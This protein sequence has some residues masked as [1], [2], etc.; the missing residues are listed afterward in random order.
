MENWP[1]FGN[2]CWILGDN[3]RISEYL[4]SIIIFAGL[5]AIPITLILY[6]MSKGD[7]SECRGWY[8]G[9]LGV[10]ERILFIVL[11][12]NEMHYVLLGWLALKGLQSPFSR[13][14]DVSSC[15]QKLLC[16]ISESYHTLLTG[17]CLSLLSGVIGGL[18][19]KHPAIP[20]IPIIH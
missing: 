4:Y 10:L 16:D 2:L 6:K 17:N 11:V 20:V 7:L 9:F 12:A 1:F 14:K 19:I 13:I 18:L 3:V 8:P 15:N 5:S